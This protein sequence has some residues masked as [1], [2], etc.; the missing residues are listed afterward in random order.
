M[1]KSERDY[2]TILSASRFHWD[3][4]ILD[5]QESSN[6]HLKCH[7]VRQSEKKYF[8]SLKTTGQRLI[9][10]HMPCSYVEAHDLANL[11]MFSL[12]FIPFLACYRCLFRCSSNYIR[13]FVRITWETLSLDGWRFAIER[14]VEERV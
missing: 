13:S 11:T 4:E 7:M 10:Y 9:I 12:K 14:N 1:T 8:V 2:L 5:F 3:E 6:I